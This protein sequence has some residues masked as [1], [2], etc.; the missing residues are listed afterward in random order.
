MIRALSEVSG[1]Y[2]GVIR[3]LSG[4]D[5]VITRS[6]PLII[7]CERLTVVVAAVI[8][9]TA[10]AVTGTVTVTGTGTGTGATAIPCCLIYK[11]HGSATFTATTT[12]VNI[13][14]TTVVISNGNGTTPCSVDSIK[15]NR[16]RQ[17]KVSQF[18][19]ASIGVH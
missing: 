14:V 12:N 17:T 16:L 7:R 13:A 11:Q 6:H 10:A 2:P 4:H 9:T 8:A 18:E 15:W 3:A 19:L 1:Q 5:P